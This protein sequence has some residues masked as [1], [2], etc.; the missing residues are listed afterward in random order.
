MCCQHRLAQLACSTLESDARVQVT[1]DDVKKSVPVWDK[2]YAVFERARVAAE[3]AKS[4]KTQAREDAR[5]ELTVSPPVEDQMHYLGNQVQIMWGNA[6]YDQSQI[7]AGVGLGGWQGMVAAAKHRFLRATCKEADV[8]EALR[9]H[10]SAEELDLPPEEPATEQAGGAAAGGAAAAGG[11][12]ATAADGKAADGKKEGGKGGAK[13]LPALK[14][15]K[16][17]ASS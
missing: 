7:W 17:K 2:V 12:S 15:K 5:A 8:N 1:A 3:G 9:N 11:S 10:I 14:K 6:L 4:D 13:G 16:G